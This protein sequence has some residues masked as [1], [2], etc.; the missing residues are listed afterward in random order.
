MRSAPVPPARRDDI[1]GLRALCAVLIVGFHAWTERTS[2]GVDVFFVVSGFLLIGS[3]ARQTL[4]LGTVDLRR[5]AVGIW[6]R[7]L[8]A[9]VVVTVI[10]IVASQVLLP[11]AFWDRA[12]REGLATSLFI[13]NLALQHY[14]FNYLARGEVMTPF[15]NGWAI[16]LQVQAYVLIG[17]LM[18]GLALWARRSD[19][20]VVRLA[21]GLT[22]V[23]L[24]SFAWAARA[25]VVDPT[26]AYFDPLARL[27]EFT[28]GGLLAL[29]LTRHPLPDRLRGPA[30]WAGLAL[31]LTTGLLWGT[32]N[33]FP[34]W[35][36]LWPAAAALLI[37]AAGADG[38]PVG[39]GRLLAWR[40]LAWLGDRSYGLYLW[41][42]PVLVFLLVVTG[43]AHADLAT[44]MLI[45]VLSIALAVAAKA[46][47]EKPLTAWLSADRSFARIM[48]R[49]ALL[50]AVMLAAVGL[51]ALH[52]SHARQSQVDQLATTRLTGQPPR[53]L[54]RTVTVPGPLVARDD[55]GDMLTDGCLAGVSED[56]LLSCR[57]GASDAPVQIALVGSSH[58]RHWLPAL[59]QIAVTRGWRIVTYTKAA[60]SFGTGANDNFGR[61]APDCAAWS[62]RVTKRLLELRP[63]LVVTV[64]TLDRLPPEQR[65]PPGH[66]RQLGAAGIP[67]LGLRDT[68]WFDHNMVDCVARSAL[69]DRDCSVPRRDR[70]PADLVPAGGWPSGVTFVDTRD[71]LCAADRCGPVVDGFMVYFDDSHMTATFARSL[72]PRLAPWIDRAL[73]PGADISPRPGPPP[74]DRL[75]GPPDR[76]GPSYRR[77]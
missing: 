32:T 52:L 14:A 42:G 12:I 48:L 58:A 49:A 1:Q 51:W 25:V 33:L 64:A 43:R 67:V 44:G 23:T 62:A 45:L 5:F 72:V 65:I 66:W 20:R 56:R 74:S 30:G 47:F 70:D 3:L 36:S 61:A 50:V 11:G 22:V 9:T 53:I 15:Q 8:P 7:L 4:Q 68:P 18:A 46:T 73:R 28:V 17:L 40:P 29:G 31:L 6:R 35:T 59:Q 60:C 69:P 76:P 38:R 13:E 54:G 24:A 55:Q 21:V 39:V 63:D 34:A 19:R 16:S 26:G 77:P 10:T 27:W 57:Y 75:P 41:Q 71:W 37:L 2:G